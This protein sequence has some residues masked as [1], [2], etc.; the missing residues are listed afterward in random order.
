MDVECPNCHALHW[1][2]ERLAQSSLTSPQFGMCCK[3]GKVQLLD[4]RDP[5]QELKDLLDGSNA[6]AREFRENIWK[7][8]RAFAFTS[9]K[10][11]EDHSI[12]S[13]NGPPVFR[14]QGELFH[15]I[16]SV[17][18][19]PGSTPTYSQLYIYDPRAALEHRRQQNSGLNSD[20]LRILQDVLRNHQY[21]QVY[22]HAH[23]ILQGYDP[24]EDVTIRLRV[25]P[26][27]DRRRYNLPT[28][29]EVAVILPQTVTNENPRDIVLQRRSG[30][31]RIIS[32]MNPAYVPLYYV[33]LF[34]Y[35]ENGWHPDMRL[36]QSAEGEDKR[37]TRLR[38]VAYYLYPRRNKY[39][40]ILRG[41]RLL[42]RYLVDMYAIIDQSR[43]Q[44]L[45]YNQPMLRASLYSGLE[46]AVAFGD[47]E[48]D[49]HN[50]GR[51]YI[52]PSSYIGGPR[53]MQQRFQDAMAIA[54]YFRRVDIF[55]TITCNPNWEE[56]TRELLPGQTAYDR[57]DLVARVFQLKKKAIL[58]EIYKHGI[59]GHAV[60]Y[61]YTIE[62]QK[63]GLP[64]MHCLI[65]LQD[66]YKLTS[67]E[68]IDSCIWA[69]WPDPEKE[70]Q[71]FEVVMQCMV[72][73]PCAAK[74]DAVCKEDGKCKRRFP[75]DFSPATVM[76]EDGFPRYYR[77]DDGRSY[78]V[79]GIPTD[80][81]W[82]VPYPP[83]L[84]SRFFCHA[85]AECV[86]SLGSFK[87]LF[88]YTYKGGDLATLEETDRNNEIQRYLDGRYISAS[89]AAHRI[90]EFDMHDQ[91]PNVVR[92]QVHL[93]GQHLVIFDPEED[94]AVLLGRASNE[95]TTLT[96]W[97]HANADPAVNEEACKWTYQEFPQHFRW[98]QKHKKWVIRRRG[99][100]VG[101]MYYVPPTAG[102]RFYLRLLL[103]V[104]RGA[105]SFE[106][107]RTY[108]RPTPYPTF[109]E[110][111]RARGLLEDNGEWEQCLREA[112]EMQ[113]GTSLRHLFATMLLF[114][115]P[116]HP[117]RLWQNFRQYICDDL[118]YRL[119]CLGYPQPTDDEVF[120]YGL[121]CLEGILKKS[122]HTLD[123]WPSMPKWRQPW[124]ERRMNGLIA[125]QLNYNRDVERIFY[126]T[127][128]PQLNQNQRHAFDHIT[129]SID[130]DQGRLFF[131]NGPGG[132]GK[133]FLYKVICSRYRSEGAVVICVASSGIAA[134]LLPLGRTAHSTFKIPIENLHNESV[135][136]IPKNTFRA[137]LLRTAKLI[138]WDEIGAQHRHAIE[139]LDRTL[140]DVRN[141][142]S[143]F[144]GLT[145]IFGGDFQ[146]TL[147]VVVRG[148]REETVDATLIHS[149]LWD[150]IEVLHLQQN[151]RLQGDPEGEEFSR[152][153]LDVGH[154]RNLDER[155]KV[156]IPADMLV[157][158]AASLIDFVYPGINSPEPP[159][160]DYF[161]NR[162]ILAPRNADVSDINGTI[163][164][165][166]AG[167]THTF[168]SANEVIH[169]DG[170]D[171]PDDIP[172]TPE[173]L[174]S[175][176]ASNLPPGELHIKKGCPLI[177][178]RNISPSQG[179]CNGTRVIVTN[180]GVR[181]LEVRII[182]G[183]HDGQV[184]FIPR[185]S[186]TS[187]S[188]SGYVFKIRRRQYPVRLAFAL[189][190]NK[191][192]GQSVK[193]VGLDLR[194]PVFGHGQLYVALSRATSRA[195]VKVLLP[196]DSA[197]WTT[198]VVYPEVLVD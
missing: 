140:R 64:H 51:R 120:D 142:E 116:A 151:M 105:K 23:E 99:F 63:R 191:A 167:E 40:T 114:C 195:H 117:D 53:H 123:N 198:N 93:P 182:G 7:Y 66:L 20:T 111:C 138:I 113:T 107:L 190:I 96:A 50:L 42:Q 56:I 126:N 28:A 155:G 13:R 21:G 194:T 47:D 24:N 121:Y 170:A 46:D 2:D 180:V 165:H 139:A 81:R 177:L 85:N 82:L 157:Q 168:Y 15:R 49:L 34:P 35:G 153:L 183:D 174:R 97:F 136:D 36:H 5:P 112:S 52:L 59:F 87:Y 54:R 176:N 102:E 31:L 181:V 147:P 19:S 69:R 186:I 192:Q 131:V 89:E 75:K 41:G 18:P 128:L 122:G 29:D 196:D 125:E 144:G 175:I 65:F 132:T 33:L 159:P 55:L 16:G 73:G 76:D 130:S 27:H 152:W 164:D 8:N 146:Q 106:D 43:L 166:M 9:M 68:A 67:V 185:I 160:P 77:P 62:F 79:N 103:T 48:I 90:F 3:S 74:A 95:R 115:E 37:L 100:A 70:P 148:S 154:G 80:N 135:C 38:Y 12:N 161:L 127:H 86:V 150:S 178:L 72:H 145:T 30:G 22:R 134:L 156:L 172:L 39:S 171:G 57:P 149:E 94:P 184:A 163:L 11:K 118:R 44:Y 58:D 10:V 189:T 98:D 25:L 83:Y 187:T 71:L 179:L 104:V 129:S 197:G 61:V 119:Q 14:I 91:V 169:E 133:T 110:A 92:L 141:N 137:D 6:Q 108:D 17:E 101:R 188:S 32:D 4:F 88:K 158:D 60:A 162:M 143:P 124:D 84:I 78:R 1:K 173:F 109:Y 193:F 45:F 26:A